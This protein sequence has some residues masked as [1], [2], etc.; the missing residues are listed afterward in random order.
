MRIKKIQ[1]LQL[2]LDSLLNQLDSDT[3]A[4]EV[5]SNIHSIFIFLQQHGITTYYAH[6][7]LIK[8]GNDITYTLNNF[9]Y[10]YDYFK[11]ENDIKSIKDIELFLKN[12]KIPI[13]PDAD[14]PIY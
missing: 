6:F 2:K 10:L 7:D 11:S 1:K 3:Y 9:N 8:W 5:L 13:N 12:T 14:S 4:L